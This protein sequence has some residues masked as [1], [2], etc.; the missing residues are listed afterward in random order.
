MKAKEELEKLL[1]K[2]EVLETRIETMESV[3]LIRV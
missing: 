1:D 3:E 2:I